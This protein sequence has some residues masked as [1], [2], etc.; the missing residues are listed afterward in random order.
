MFL[1][2]DFPNNCFLWNYKFCGEFIYYRT[3]FILEKFL[4]FLKIS[5]FSKNL[6][7]ISQYIFYRNSLNI[8]RQDLNRQKITKSILE[9]YRNLFSKIFETLFE[10]RFGVWVWKFCQKIYVS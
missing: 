1:D 2:F 9:Q 10:N 4:N 3:Y 6:G 5:K 7:E 8:I